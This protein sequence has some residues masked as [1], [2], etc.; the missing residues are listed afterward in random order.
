M[1][2]SATIRSSPTICVD[3]VPLARDQCP[4][5]SG[6]LSDLTWDE[7]AMFLHGGYGATQRTTI[8][9][10]VGCSWSK[11]PDVSTLRPDRQSQDSQDSG[12]SRSH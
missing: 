5:C 6:A 7:P 9:R 11:R 4:S 8:R 10:C 1:S 12:F 2:T 3:I